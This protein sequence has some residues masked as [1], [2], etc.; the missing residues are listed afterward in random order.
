MKIGNR[1]V[2]PWSR[3]NFL[4]RIIVL[5]LFFG[6]LFGCIFAIINENRIIAEMRREEQMIRQRRESQQR[7]EAAYKSRIMQEQAIRSGVQN[8]IDGVKK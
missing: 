6:W 5:G 8:A 3:K 2:L 4:P 1:I 7:R